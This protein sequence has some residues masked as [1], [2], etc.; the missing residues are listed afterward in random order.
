MCSATDTTVRGPCLTLTG[1][2]TLYEAK[3]SA[4]TAK[5]AV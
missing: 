2:L 4:S 3:K 1:G 5:T